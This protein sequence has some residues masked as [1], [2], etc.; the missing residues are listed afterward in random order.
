MA[1]ERRA[2]ND[3]SHHVW[4]AMFDIDHFKRINDN[5]GHVYGDEVILLL[6]QMMRKS[7][8]QSDV[9]FRFGGEEFVVLL[10]S[11]DEPT[12]CAALERFRERVASHHFPQVGRVTVSIGFAHIGESDYPEIVLDR[13]DKALYYAKQNGRNC[14]YGYESLASR[15]MLAPTTSGSIDLF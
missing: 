2:M 12:A 13:A 3:E 11:L 8:R 5:Y 4:L 10:N 15:G 14:T 1:E 7:F 6:A 9:L